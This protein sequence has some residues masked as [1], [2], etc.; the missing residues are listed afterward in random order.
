MIAR[1][2]RVTVPLTVLCALTGAFR[3][4]AQTTNPPTLGINLLA[5][6][7]VRLTWTNAASFFRLEQTDSLRSGATW[8]PVSQTPVPQGGL[9]SITLGASAS[10]RY[11]RLTLE[12]AGD[13]DGDRLPTSWELQYGYDPAVADS[14]SNGIR[15]DLE[16]ADGDG[17][18][19]YDEARLGTNPQNPD[20]DG[21][22]YD[23]YGENLEGTDPTSAASVPKVVVASIAAS[24][25]NAVAETPASGTPLNLVSSF[26]SYLNA[27]PET[28]TAGTPIPAASTTASYVNAVAET[29]PPGTP[30]PLASAVASY[31]NATPES[32]TP[33]TLLNPVSPVV[34]YRNQ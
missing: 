6:A 32:P 21:D 7:Q 34:S 15:D 10:T 3:G 31:V 16:D 19:N 14:D 29:I 22:G 26:A 24:F 33:G 13:P 11:F 20:T 30:I 25:L 1:L 5:G 8:S 17:V 4:E 9:L 18:I 27:L 28:I 12:T 2:R 23:D